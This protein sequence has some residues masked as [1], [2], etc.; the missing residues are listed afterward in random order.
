VIVHPS[1]PGAELWEKAAEDLAA[2][3]G[4]PEALAVLA[5]APRLRRLGL[6]VPPLP[7]QQ[8]AEIA[9]YEL[10]ARTGAPDP[11]SAY[12]ALL[13]RIASLAAALEHQHSRERRARGQS[14]P[15]T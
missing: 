15:S 13:R 14:P 11:F 12:N 5:A 2:G 4:S 10:L 3:V 6:V 1:L 8:S 7:L 9:L